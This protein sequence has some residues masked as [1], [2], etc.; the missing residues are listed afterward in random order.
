MKI[1]SHQ[2]NAELWATVSIGSLIVNIVLLIVIML[3]ATGHITIRSNND[4]LVNKYNSLANQYSSQAATTNSN[5]S[6]LNNTVNR[7][8]PN[9][10]V[11][12][13]P[14]SSFTSCNGTVFG[15]TVSLSCY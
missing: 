7:L 10:S 11:I 2:R 5:L 6:D 13:A 9:P 3:F 12:K 15:S 1:D 4:A 8:K 14:T